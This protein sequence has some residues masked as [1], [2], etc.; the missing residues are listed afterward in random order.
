MLARQG[1]QRAARADLQEG[2][3]GVTRERRADRRREAHRLAEVAG[4]VIGAGGVGLGHPG[5]GAG[6]DDGKARRGECNGL[7]RGG[8]RRQG[9]VHHGRVE[10]VRGLQHAR[11]HPADLQLGTPGFDGYARAGDD[12]G[13]RAVLGRQRQ[14]LG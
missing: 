2:G 8:K 5:A 12:A 14:R 13:R 6:G 10:G 4:P 1:G 3:V 11:L 7:D 9:R